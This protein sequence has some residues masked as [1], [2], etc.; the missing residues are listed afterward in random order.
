MFVFISKLLKTNTKK[1]YLIFQSIDVNK[2]FQELRINEKSETDL[3]YYDA[4]S[5]VMDTFVNRSRLDKQKSIDSSKANQ[6]YS[7][8]SLPN[9]SAHKPSKV[10]A[11]KKQIK[12]RTTRKEN[13]RKEWSERDLVSKKHSLNLSKRRNETSEVGRDAS[14]PKTVYQR[15]YQD[16]EKRRN[17]SNERSM[18]RSHSFWSSKHS[19]DNAA[20][21]HIIFKRLNKD[22]HDIL[23]DIIH[24]DVQEM[25][26]YTYFIQAV[27]QE[28]NY[29]PIFN[30]G[31]DTMNLSLDKVWYLLI[32]L[33]FIVNYDPVVFEKM[34]LIQ[35]VKEER[36]ER[37][38]WAK[39][40]KDSNR[41]NKTFTESKSTF[42][43]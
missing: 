32:K 5:D 7:N 16:S 42:H 26:N 3:K 35:E 33:G 41:N 21:D 27:K 37:K 39:F 38:R 34:D 11:K 22:F 20:N 23:D 29:H 28:T 17:S 43:F 8:S 14:N 9:S 6:R 1:Q 31:Y 2:T 13:D 15:L 18:E 12:K 40:R 10:K 19:V 36:K 25:K 4:I 30:N 24:K